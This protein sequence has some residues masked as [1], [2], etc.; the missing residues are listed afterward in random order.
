MASTASSS[1]RDDTP[2]ALFS[3]TGVGRRTGEPV[4]KAPTSSGENVKV[5][6]C[7]CSSSHWRSL[8]GPMEVVAV[9]L[10]WVIR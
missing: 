7:R 6:A 3:V 5:W 1:T 9:E 4:V 8:C 2:V 10:G